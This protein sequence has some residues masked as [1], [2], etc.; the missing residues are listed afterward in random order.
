M[1]VYI[2]VAERPTGTFQVGAG[3]SSVEN[4]IATA[5]IQQ[6]NLFGNGQSLFIRGEAAYTGNTYFDISNDPISRRNPF[7]V[8][9][10]SLGYS[11]AGGHYQ[12]ELWSRNFTDVQYTVNRAMGNTVQGI[13]GAPRTFGVQLNYTY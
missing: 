13:P 11:S 12:L 5:Q 1:N 3:F 8:Y 2:E 4:F 10:A 7:G 9:N 6:A